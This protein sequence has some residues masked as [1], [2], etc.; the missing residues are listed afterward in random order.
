MWPVKGVVVGYDGSPDSRAALEWATFL[1][2][3][4]GGRLTVLHAYDGAA[5][6]A[7]EAAE[8]VRRW[9]GAGDREIAE[10]TGVTSSG[11]APDVLLTAA[12]DAELLVIGSGGR[13]TAASRWI[14]PVAW[15][16]ARRAP[17][18][19]VTV[20]S[21]FRGAGPERGAVVVGVDGSRHGLAAVRFAADTAAALEVRLCLVAV[22]RDPTHADRP[23]GGAF[24]LEAGESAVDPSTYHVAAERLRAAAESVNREHAELAVR[25]QAVG[26]RPVRVLTEASSRAG[27]VVVGRHLRSGP[28]AATADV[29][30]GALIRA[31]CPVAVVP[32]AE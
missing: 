25:L 1:R 19:V 4:R 3:R 21:R 12:V 32:S 15:E 20:C 27:L 14:G 5:S 30:R 2:L 7:A 10:I 11:D 6:V 18:P 22:Y 28:G 13:R 31:R 17:C 26:G 24:R 16:V 23:V 29:T 8:R 9:S